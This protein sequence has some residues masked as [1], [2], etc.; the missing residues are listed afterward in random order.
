MRARRQL[1]LDG[2]TWRDVTPALDDGHHTGLADDRPVIEPQDTPGRAQ[3][4]LGRRGHAVRPGHDDPEQAGPDVVDLAARVTQTGEPDH[5]GPQVQSRPA[6]QLEQGAQ[7]SA[8][9]NAF[10]AR[11]VVRHRW[12]GRV[13]CKEPHPGRWGA[14]PADYIGEAREP[15]VARELAVAP[16]DASL[17]GYVAHDIPE[18][19]YVARADQPPARKPAVPDTK[20]A[21]SPDVEVVL[22]GEPVASTRTSC[23]CTGGEAPA[24]WLGLLVLLGRRRRRA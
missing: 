23:G 7:P 13:D 3:R 21:P 5:G 2:L 16:R 20:P 10:Q 4:R 1:D 6:G 24:G 12:T 17:A 22:P 18:I 11:Y 15:I 9:L 14:P 19:R 8:E